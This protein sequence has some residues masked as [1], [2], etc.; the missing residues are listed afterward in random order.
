MKE[1]CEAIIFEPHLMGACKDYAIT[2]VEEVAERCG[3]E[4]LYH[5]LHKD[6][7]MTM[8]LLRCTVHTMVR[9]CP[10]KKGS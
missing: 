4:V 6:T 5:I 1:L 3:G 7:A 10:S 8:L 9:Q 2:Y